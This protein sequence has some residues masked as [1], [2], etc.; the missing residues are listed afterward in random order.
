MTDI[1]VVQA[2]ARHKP[3]GL[4]A[5]VVVSLLL[6]GGVV[7][8]LASAGDSARSALGGE[9][10]GTIAD[11]ETSDADTTAVATTGEVLTP[12]TDESVPP[13]TRDSLAPDA[14]DGG[15]LSYGEFVAALKAN[16]QATVDR[17]CTE[18]PPGSVTAPNLVGRTYGSGLTTF[19]AAERTTDH[20]L[21]IRVYVLCA[22]T[23]TS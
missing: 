21:K 12:V 20:L 8:L 4:V 7:V 23:T 13:D 19:T 3:G 17:F 2:G 1:E 14:G 22:V 5:I 10:M 9:L 11:T 6:I 16:D 18:N 15:G